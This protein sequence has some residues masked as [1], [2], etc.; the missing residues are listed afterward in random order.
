MAEQAEPYVSDLRSTAELFEALRRAYLADEGAMDG[1]ATLHYRGGPEEFE[2]ARQLTESAAAVDREI[3][4]LVLAQLGW[5][6]RAFLEE[7][8][9]ILL[10]LLHSPEPSV[11]AAAASALG[12]RAHPRAVYALAGLATH[13]DSGVRF[14]TA[15]ALGHHLDDAAAEAVAAEALMILCRD[16]DRDVRNWAMFGLAQMESQDSPSIREVLT[17]GSKEPDDEI[18]GEAI[19]GLAIRKVPGTA[20]IIRNELAGEVVFRLTLDAARELG[21][22]SLVPDLLEL[23]ASEDWDGDE[24]LKS[25]LD[26]AIQRCREAATGPAA[27]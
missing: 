8:V 16:G 12:H 17:E 4:A 13:A 27:A 24:S 7:S 26:L 2:A 20:D 15:C 14:S 21:D 11:V 9:D 23:Q 10:A 5:G 18:R 25:D 22:P 6:Q 1:L 19:V 3:G